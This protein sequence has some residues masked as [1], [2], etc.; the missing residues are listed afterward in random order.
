MSGITESDEFGEG[1]WSIQ[2]AALPAGL[3]L[4]DVN[5]QN[6]TIFPKASNG[7]LLEATGASL[8]SGDKYTWAL[9][10]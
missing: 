5:S 10:P 2:S 7:D 3:F 8:G 4:G 9:V 6:A 1:A